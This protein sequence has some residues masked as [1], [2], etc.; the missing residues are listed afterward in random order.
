MGGIAP[1]SGRVAIE[2]E[3]AA[4]Y[5]NEAEE[6]L[7]RPLSSQRT[8]ARR[9]FAVEIDP[10]LPLLELGTGVGRDVR[11]FAK[12]DLTV[13]GVDLSLEQARHAQAAGAHQV[14]ASA[15]FLP[16][17]DD[18]FAALWSMST[19]M[20]VPNSVIRQTLSEVRRVL[21]P[22]A[23]AAIGVWGGPDVEDY[24]DRRDNESLRRLFSRRSD[25]TWLRLL[26][27]LGV[28]TTFETWNRDDDDFWY[29]W[30]LV[31]IT[32]RS[33]PGA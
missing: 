12:H 31:R 9:R 30:A 20:H 27:F 17:R 4:Y 2:A 24:G 32:E 1:D 28:V 26:D 14:L 5:D 22:D 3:L 21:A 29:Q 15:T 33:Y 13:I 19:L 11:E 6:R 25:E 16:F 18:S 8:E 23:V 10:S 7:H